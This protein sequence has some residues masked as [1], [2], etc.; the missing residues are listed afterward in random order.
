MR[1]VL[2][3]INYDKK[4]RSAGT[5][6]GGVA[7]NSVPWQDLGSSSGRYHN[8]FNNNGIIHILA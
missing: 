1:L 4:I 5:Y 8:N 2:A 3:L 7:S 6:S